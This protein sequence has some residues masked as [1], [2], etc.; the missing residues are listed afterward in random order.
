MVKNY[1]PVVHI[2]EAVVVGDEAEGRFVDH[3]TARR[4]VDYPVRLLHKGIH[5]HLQYPPESKAQLSRYRNV[6]ILRLKTT[7]RAGQGKP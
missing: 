2:V 7:Y 3:Q 5:P 1:T 4:Q 6:C